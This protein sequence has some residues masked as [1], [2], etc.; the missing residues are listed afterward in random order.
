MGN[1]IGDKSINTPSY[2][3]YIKD[4]MINDIIGEKNSRK[5]IATQNASDAKVLEDFLNLLHDYK[6]HKGYPDNLIMQ[7]TRQDLIDAASAIQPAIRSRIGGMQKDV[8]G[9]DFEEYFD[10]LIPNII[11]SAADLGFAKIIEDK[12]IKINFGSERVDMTK[13]F[14]EEVTHEMAL[15]APH[16]C[17]RLT[18]AGVSNAWSNKLWQINEELK[19]KSLSKKRRNELNQQKQTLI[20]GRDNMIQTYGNHLA[21][22]GKVDTLNDTTL[23]VT[24]ESQRLPALQRVLK[25]LAQSSFSDKAF[26]KNQDITIGQTNS[27]RVF[28]AVSEE[29][30][31]KEKL[32]RW[33]RLLRCMDNHGQVPGH[34]DV[35]LMFYQIRYMYELTGYGLR[36]TENKI[37][38]MVGKT[39]AKYFVYFNPGQGYTVLSAS[40]IIYNML[41]AI[42]NQGDFGPKTKSQVNTKDYALHAR[43]KMRM[44]KGIFDYA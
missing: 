42:D 31:L 38:Q 13:N 39:G 20:A 12:N 26:K 16:Y 33:N 28:L 19:R 43:L 21:V 6:P 3:S 15:R 5:A 7:F 25:L 17:L 10:K 34:Q 32:D 23:E 14:S 1:K 11:Y 22:K 41:D 18:Q 24:L 8:T 40:S 2:L 9:N 35:P 29:G 37:T 27:L 44:H 30:T 36:Y 4:K